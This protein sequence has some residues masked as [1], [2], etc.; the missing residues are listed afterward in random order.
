[1]NRKFKP[2]VELDLGFYDEGA[3]VSEETGESAGEGV[4]RK[5]EAK[6][7]KAKPKNPLATVKYGKQKPTQPDKDKKPAEETNKKGD[8]NDE[9]RKAEFEKLI[10]G[11]FKDLFAQRMQQIINDRFKKTK[12][13]EAQLEAQNEL[14]EK[15]AAKYGVGTNNVDALSKAIDEDD[16]YY[17]QEALKAGMTVEQFKDYRRTM[18][19]NASLKRAQ[20][21]A[22]NRAQGEQVYADW[23]KQAEVLKDK[24]PEFD[25][26]QE[27][28]DPKTGKRFLDLLRHNIDVENAHFLVHKDEILGGAMQYSAQ[29]AAKRVTDGIL[30]KGRRPRENGANTAAAGQVVKADPSKFTKADRDEI[31]RRVLRGEK[32]I[33]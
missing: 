20:E 27:I 21:Q 19:E 33:L 18:A 31:S 12:K 9:E 7:G 32:I 15:L 3:K 24:F 30:A 4:K 11:E 28:N 2:L 23:L 1:M 26:E 29:Q 17:E 10:K 25:L 13:L 22:K 16:T 14:L 8:K 6:P 5:K